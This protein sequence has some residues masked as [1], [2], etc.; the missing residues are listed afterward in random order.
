MCDGTRCNED[1]VGAVGCIELA[2]RHFD[3]QDNLIVIGG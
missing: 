3:I 1:R 2:V